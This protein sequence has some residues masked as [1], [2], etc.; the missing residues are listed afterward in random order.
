[1]SDERQ[2]RGQGI[3][4]DGTAR[5]KFLKRSGGVAVA[6]PA[7]ALLLAAQSKVAMARPYGTPPDN[8]PS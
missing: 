1:M 6:A 4:S 7:V 2:E 3:S 8:P 5:R